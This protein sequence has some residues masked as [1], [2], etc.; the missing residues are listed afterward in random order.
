MAETQ[1]GM[2]LWQARLEL[3]M[4]EKLRA[5][6]EKI[7]SR[8]QAVGNKLQ[9]IEQAGYIIFAVAVI[10]GLTGAWGLKSLINAHQHIATLE[11]SIASLSDQV[12]EWEDIKNRYV[13]ELIEV[14]NIGIVALRVEATEVIDFFKKSVA[15]DLKQQLEHIII[16]E[17]KARSISV[18]GS[19][20]IKVVSIGT[21]SG[22]GLIQIFNG[23]TSRSIAGIG[24]ISGGNGGVW[25][26]NRYG[27]R[28]LDGETF[29]IGGNWVAYNAATGRAISS[30]SGRPP[31]FAGEAVIV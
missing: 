6:E 31:G 11:Q 18:V 17:V 13:S 19:S 27:V 20:G 14:K 9:K 28:L 15:T 23:A 24:A 3:S 5:N 16:D 30:V 21:A 10:F 2:E 7:D 25:L 4:S 8:V 22:G 29:G 12:K 26:N 1:R